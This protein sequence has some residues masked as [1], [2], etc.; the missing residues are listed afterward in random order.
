MDRRHSLC[1]WQCRE[2]GRLSQSPQGDA[3]ERERGEGR[4]RKGGVRETRR[5]R[6]EREGGEGGRRGRE[7]GKEER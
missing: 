7:E 4:R 6:A 2:L 5:G 1:H 3:G